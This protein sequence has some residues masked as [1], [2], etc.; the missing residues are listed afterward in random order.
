VA[1]LRAGEAPPSEVERLDDPM[2]RRER[3]MLGLRLDEPLR[4]AAVGGEVDRMALERLAA[5]G[6]VERL[7][8]DE[9]IR[10]TPR[11]RLLGDAVTADLL[12][13]G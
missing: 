12:V 11:G 7:D 6:L 1:S 10:L 5:G 8:G 3:L 2:K 4:L 13:A 9:A